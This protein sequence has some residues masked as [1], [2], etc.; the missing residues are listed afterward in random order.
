[1][2]NITVTTNSET[3]GSQVK[4]PT[5]TDDS[6]DS[7]YDTSDCA[8]IASTITTLFGIVSTAIV[9]TGS[10]GNLNSVT[11][12]TAYI[13]EFQVKVEE[14]TFDGTDTT[15]TALVGGSS[16]SLPASDNFIIFLN[17]TL[18]VKGSSCTRH[19][20][21]TITFNEAPLPGM[22]FYGFYFG[23]LTLLDTIAPFFDNSKKTFI[24]KIEQPTILS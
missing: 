4:D 17:S 11:R 15:F 14:L 20:G 24:L 1:M 2:R 13:P 19:T 3:V 5:I 18:Q 16:Y 8:D 22:D 23:K 12:Q 21:S 7:T 9:S 6:G 10:P